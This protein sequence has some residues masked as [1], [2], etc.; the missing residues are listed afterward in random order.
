[1]PDAGAAGLCGCACQR[2]RV[3]LEADEIP[4]ITVELEDDAEDVKKTVIP[5]DTKT[6]TDA[7]A[8]RMLRAL[9]S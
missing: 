2:G 9:I 1:M 7:Q 4:S 6:K 3:R 5:K 8:W